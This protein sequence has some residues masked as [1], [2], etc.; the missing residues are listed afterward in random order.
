MIEG[1]KP[2]PSYKP[3]ELPTLDE[4]PSHW[5][6]RRAKFLF[7]EVDERSQTGAEELLSVSHKTGITPRS[8]KNVTM[9]KAESYVGHKLCRPNDLAINTMW[10]WMGALGVSRHVG[11]VSPAYGVYRPTGR[12]GLVPA[13]TDALLRT[14]A[15]VHEY[16]RRSTGIQSSRL[17]LYPEEFLRIPLLVPPVGEQHAIAKFID[18]ADRRIRRYIRAKQKLINLLE[19]Q[20]QAII[21]QA[22]TRGLSPDVRLKPSGIEW[23]G[24]VPEHWEIARLGTHLLGVDQGWSPRAAEGELEETQW[25]VLS[26]S[27]IRRGRFDSTALKPI[28]RETIVPQ[29]IELSDGD[30]VIT[31]SNTRKLV[32]DVAI[33]KGSRRRTIM[34]DLMY[35]LRPKASADSHYLLYSL[36]SRGCRLQMEREARGSSGTMPKLSQRHVTGLLL[37]LP[38]IEE[39]AAIA[40]NLHDAIVRL[41]SVSGS[42]MDEISLLREYRTR[43]ISDVVTGKL[44]V[45]EAAARLPDD[46]DPDEPDLVD[47]LDPTDDDLP[48][49]EESDA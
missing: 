42:A 25:A 37:A 26:L 15:F 47:D 5:D 34:S 9:F 36:L 11:I 8:Q 4:V 41:D 20:K 23:L 49:D 48:P 24:D 16:N 31:R 6:Q 39:Q 3:A 13:Y 33:V 14:P 40:K 27:A 46:P 30:I 38:P 19:E 29:G 10:A 32:G 1:L 45:R 12:G 22:V 18:H 43:L 7:R 28:P 17:R 21:H 35:R 44:D 2:Y